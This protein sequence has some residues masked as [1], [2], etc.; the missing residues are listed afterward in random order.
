MCSTN[1]Y[2]TPQIQKLLT[3]QVML[4]RLFCFSMY[5]RNNNNVVPLTPAPEF[6]FSGDEQA[7]GGTGP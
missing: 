3:Y 5:A 6:A 1:I 7:V 2:P 4:L